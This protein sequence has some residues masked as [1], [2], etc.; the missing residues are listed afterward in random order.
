M[1]ISVAGIQRIG[2]TPVARPSLTDLGKQ[3]AASATERAAAWPKVQRGR[4]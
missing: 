2:V 1:T 4:R 3:P